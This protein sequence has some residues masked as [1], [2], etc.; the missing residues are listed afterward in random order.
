[1]QDTL[2]LHGPDCSWAVSGADVLQK[3]FMRELRTSVCPSYSKFA[4]WNLWSHRGRSFQVWLAWL[5]QKARNRICQP[6]SPVALSL[7]HQ[8]ARVP[9]QLVSS[10]HVAHRPR[11]ESRKLGP[12]QRVGLSSREQ[13]WNVLTKEGRSS[14]IYGTP[15]WERTLPT[16]QLFRAFLGWSWARS[17]QGCWASKAAWTGPWLHSWML[18]DLSGKQLNSGV[19]FCIFFFNSV[20]SQFLKHISKPPQNQAVVSCPF[21]CH[22]GDSCIAQFVQKCDSEKSL[23]RGC[24]LSR[25]GWQRRETGSKRTVTCS[26]RPPGK[27]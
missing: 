21:L 4:N 26:L 25:A 27:A 7:G 5:R 19:F 16:V 23:G 3:K 18:W 12:W 13:T 14:Q 10:V 11:Q 24:A 15:A 8:D 6:L 17:E 9:S 20:T 1:M 22:L 2:C